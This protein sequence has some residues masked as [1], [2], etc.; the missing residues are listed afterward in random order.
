MFDRA[1][2]SLCRLGIRPRISQPFVVGF[3]CGKV[4]N[5]GGRMRKVKKRVPNVWG[6]IEL[7]K[8]LTQLCSIFI[9]F[10]FLRC[11][12]LACYVPNVAKEEYMRSVKE[13]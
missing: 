6:L 5:L 8:M 11:L 4:Q 1:G 9:A 12:L 2:L 13:V 3:G 10:M 7:L